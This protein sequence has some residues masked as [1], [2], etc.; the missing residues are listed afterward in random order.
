M[1]N[2]HTSDAT[3]AND[4][5]A[6][7]VLTTNARMDQIDPDAWNR[8]VSDDDPSL[9]HEFLKA[10]ESSESCSRETGWI[11]CHITATRDDVLLGG[12]P[13]YL[14]THS[15][16]EFV[17]DWAWANAYE[18]A[19]LAY[20]PKLLIASPFTPVSGQRILCC[21]DV[22]GLQIRE[23]IASALPIIA[24][25]LNASSVHCIF[26]Q[27]SDLE[28][29]NASGF[30][31]REGR[32]FHW[33]NAAYARFEDFLGALSSKKRK[34]IARER[35]RVTD[36]GMAMRWV[37]G[38]A[39]EPQHIDLLYACYQNTIAE[40][41]SYAYLNPRFFEHL[42]RDLPEAVQ[43]L[44]AS[45]NNLDIAC[46]FFLRGKNALYGR[47]W[48]SLE[49]VPD[50]HFE[51]CYYS[52]IEYCIAQGISRFEAGAQGEH[53]L[54][55][56]LTPQKTQSAHWLANPGFHDAVRRF[57]REEEDHLADYSRMLESHSP[58]KRTE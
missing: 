53:K 26:C 20:Y 56:G 57:T 54:S 22:N 35:R 48:G 39:I 41:G 37:P 30:V 6:R 43:L 15:Y 51:V 36:Q 2:E 11:P 29:L 9:R 24:K 13:C 5:G 16:G 55:R 19:G 8:M 42:V 46:G 7:V 49:H 23:Q 18:R 31:P 58:F 40:H 52:P 32:Q 27:P 38:N 28:A 44:I 17:F 25:K 14:K 4:K 45:R 3:S 1:S 33:H 10:L 50:L 12:A 34:N 47:Y 21:P